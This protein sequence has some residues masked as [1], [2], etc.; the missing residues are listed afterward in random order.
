MTKENLEKSCEY[1]FP[2]GEREPCFRVK[3][4]GLGCCNLFH[5][6]YKEKTKEDCPHHRISQIEK[7][8]ERK[9]E[10]RKYK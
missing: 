4:Y 10:N 8:L 2:K 3:V 1:M 7:E 9:L 5:E 6:S